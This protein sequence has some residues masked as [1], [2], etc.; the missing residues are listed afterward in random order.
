MRHLRRSFVLLQASLLLSFSVLDAT[1]ANPLT[2]ATFTDIV[3]LVTVTNV[4]DASEHKA[5]VEE[6]F[7]TPNLVSTGRR[8]RTELEA[9]DG[10][11]I[12]LG[13]STIFSFANDTRVLNLREGSLL[14]HSPTGRGGG[15]I[16]TATATATVI[17][18]T[19][20]VV[21]TPDGGF[22]LLVLE[23][24][25]KV[26]F[27]DGSSRTLSSGQLIFTK[28]GS[29]PSKPRP[30]KVMNFD[31]GRL[32][33]SSLLV[34]GFKQPLASLPKIK[35]SIQKQHQRLKGGR[36]KKAPHPLTAPPS[37]S[38]PTNSTNPDKQQ[39]HIDSTIRTQGF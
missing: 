28:A 32:A 34:D 15:R 31:L 18:T 33:E 22:K 14:F 8:S 29:T 25:A 16:E 38:D 10:T 7:E 37:S 13:S 23:G 4:S 1:E 20:I 21:V 3:N 35:A 30:S 26:T 11:V 17:G 6:V 36:L 12:R 24:D 27:T 19:I 2:K 9:E 5:Q 39:I